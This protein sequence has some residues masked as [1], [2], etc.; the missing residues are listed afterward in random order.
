VHQLV[1]KKDFDNT[2]MHGTYGEKCEEKEK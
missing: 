1:N 2:K